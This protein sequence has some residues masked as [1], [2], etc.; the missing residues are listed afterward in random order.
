MYK[1]TDYFKSPILKENFIGGIKNVN[2]IVDE[3]TTELGKSLDYGSKG[4]SFIIK[5]GKELKKVSDMQD[6]LL[7]KIKNINKK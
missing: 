1:K 2:D 6:N 3:I 4:G 7:K 5:I